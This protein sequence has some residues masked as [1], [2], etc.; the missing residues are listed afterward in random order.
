MQRRMPAARSELSRTQSAASGWRTSRKAT[1][2]RPRIRSPK[3]LD[4]IFSSFPAAFATPARA[5]RSQALTPHIRNQ[6]STTHPQSRNTTVAE[7]F[8]VSEA[9]RGLRVGQL[10]QDKSDACEHLLNLVLLQS[11]F[12]EP[13]VAERSVNDAGAVRLARIFRSVTGMTP[14]AYRRS[15]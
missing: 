14:S 10:F 12:L 7:V 15:L 3:T 1:L 4:S 6:C 13:R 8:E 11:R 2:H 5:R 9:H